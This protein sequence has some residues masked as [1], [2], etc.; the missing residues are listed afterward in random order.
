MASWSSIDGEIITIT[1]ERSGN[2]TIVG[3][4]LQKASHWLWNNG[5]GNGGTEE[6]EAEFLL[7]T[8]QEK[9]DMI[10]QVYIHTIKELAKN[11]NRKEL[12]DIALV[13]SDAIV[14]E[15]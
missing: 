5:Y 13:E 6:G 14:T 12:F 11:Q 2:K 8:N 15:Y 1:I 3:D 4:T 9:L 10:E 7:L